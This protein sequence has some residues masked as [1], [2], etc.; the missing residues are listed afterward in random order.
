ML[1]AYEHRLPAL[2][3][4]PDHYGFS[5]GG[6]SEQLLQQSRLSGVWLVGEPTE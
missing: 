1:A 3:A 4:E 5:I 2:N 6:G